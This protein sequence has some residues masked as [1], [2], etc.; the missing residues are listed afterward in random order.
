M[1]LGNGSYAFECLP[2]DADA[3][4]GPTVRVTGGGAVRSGP[5]AVPVSQQDLI[6]PTLAYQKWIQARMVE[7]ARKTDVLRA[8]SC[9][10]TWCTSG[11][12]PPTAPS[13]TPTPRSTGP[14]PGRRPEFAHLPPPW[15][16]RQGDRRRECA[17]SA[18]RSWAVSAPPVDRSGTED[19]VPDRA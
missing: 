19:N 2:D 14:R 11:W 9:P 15:P 13:A 8:H 16:T 6:P 1:T 12:A 17:W 18:V 4:T 7:L 10:R 5:A 3:V